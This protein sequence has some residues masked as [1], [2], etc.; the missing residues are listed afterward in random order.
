MHRYEKIWLT[1]STV[2]IIG[3]MLIIGYQAFALDM[4]P[5][6]GQETIDPQ[7]VEEHP[8]FDDTGIHQIGENEYEVVMT[9]QIF[10]FDPMELEFPEGS[11]VH[12][13][14]TSKDVVHGFQI[15][16]T[17]VNAMI[18]PGHVTTISHT[19]DEPGE[20]LV[21]CNE[22]CGAGHELMATEITIK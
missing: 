19:F 13:T 14:L 6:S 22:Y 12:F 2:I 21:V 5:P 1:A 3:F 9:L 8:P 4:G 11:T 18:T 15:A 7:N 16:G 20:Y 10:S 17:N